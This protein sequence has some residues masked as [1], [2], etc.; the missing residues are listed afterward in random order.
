MI[1]I[2]A[3]SVVAIIR[4]LQILSSRRGGWKIIVADHAPAHL[5]MAS[6]STM[7]DQREGDV[8]SDLQEFM[9]DKQIQEAAERMGMRFKL[10]SAKSHHSVGLAEAVS[11]RTKLLNYDVF[12]DKCTHIFDAFSRAATIEEQINDRIIAVCPDG[13]IIT[14]NSF[15]Y[16]AGLH[17]NIPARDLID[18]SHSGD[19]KILAQLAESRR[20]TIST[21]RVYTNHYVDHLLTFT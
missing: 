1:P 4:G 13:T 8:P 17:S 2:E 10:V 20:K 14:P 18:L 9:R 19:Q 21:V 5:S 15:A 6:E 12:K 7:I 3:M 11:R 16:S